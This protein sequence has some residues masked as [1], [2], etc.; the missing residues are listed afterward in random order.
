MDTGGGPIRHRPRSVPLTSPADVSAPID[1]LL[2]W[3]EGTGLPE[4]W[5][6]TVATWPGEVPRALPDVLHH[7]RA[8][9]D[10]VTVGVHVGSTRRD[11]QL[12]SVWCAVA[13]EWRGRGLA[14][15]LV[16]RHLRWA[17]RHDRPHVRAH[18]PAHC[19]AM[20]VANLKAGL[21]V[22]GSFTDAD[23]VVYVI[24]RGTA[25]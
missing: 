2:T 5:S 20:L 13:P 10:G 9:H 19:P 23:G 16:A 14:Q 3:H 12:Q 11:G 24:F 4:D 8:I 22:V 17:A 15:R 18:T 7:A 21:A 6:S 25:L 1:V